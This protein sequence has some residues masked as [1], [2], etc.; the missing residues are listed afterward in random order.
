MD[1]V[2]PFVA[3]VIYPTTPDAQSRQADN[4]ARIAS[5]KIPFKAIRVIAAALFALI[6][7]WVLVRGI[8]Q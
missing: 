2:E 6:G 1:M 7:V 5:E 8:P 3:L 4:L